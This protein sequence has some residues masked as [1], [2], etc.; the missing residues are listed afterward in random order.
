MLRTGMDAKGLSFVKKSIMKLDTQSAEKV[1][2]TDVLFPI[3]I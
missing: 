3:F 1:E 2:A